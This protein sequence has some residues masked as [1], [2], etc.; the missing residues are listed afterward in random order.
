VRS[1]HSGPFCNGAGIGWVSVNVDHLGPFVAGQCQAEEA[2]HLIRKGQIGWPSKGDVVGNAN[3]STRSPVSPLDFLTYPI[4]ST[5]SPDFAFLFA[6]DPSIEPYSPDF[7]GPNPK[8][9]KS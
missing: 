4:A 2:M 6:T 7:K 1:R 5:E 8:S 9:Q 3:S